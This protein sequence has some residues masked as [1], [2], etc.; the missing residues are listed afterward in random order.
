LRYR[1][2]SKR[3]IE[4]CS[5]D[6]QFTVDINRRQQKEDKT[7]EKEGTMKKEEFK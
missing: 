4:T 5:K 1:K 2:K 7:K 3:K 6:V